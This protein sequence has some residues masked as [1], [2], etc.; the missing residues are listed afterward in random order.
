FGGDGMRARANA[1]HRP[2]APPLSPPP[3]RRPAARAAR[4]ARPSPAG[5]RSPGRAP[6][7]RAAPRRRGPS[8]P[9]AGR[10]PPAGAA[11]GAA[12]AGA[13]WVPCRRDHDAVDRC[14]ALSVGEHDFTA[15][16]PTDTAHL[17]FERNV[18]TCEWR[19][20]PLADVREGQLCELWIEADA[21][22]RHMVRVLV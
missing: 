10:W 12:P 6:G 4:A 3:R 11:A 7:A 15:F 21:F 22:M 19:R 17:R 20:F 13:L 9:R 5:P 14:A 8:P 2:R 16:T 1:R 18:I